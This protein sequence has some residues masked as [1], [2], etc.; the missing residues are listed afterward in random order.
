MQ[1]NIPYRLLTKQEPSFTSDP[2]SIEEGDLIIGFFLDRSVPDGMTLQDASVSYQAM[3]QFSEDGSVW[4]GGSGFTQYGGIL[5]EGSGTTDDP[6]VVTKY[7]GIFGDIPLGAHFMRVVITG[8]NMTEA[9]PIG[10][11]GFLRSTSNPDSSQGWPQ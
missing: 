4:T 8:I 1:V 5:L 2:L 6:L 7:D 9:T 10:L 11:L 3:E